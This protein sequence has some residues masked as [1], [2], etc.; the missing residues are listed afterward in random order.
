MGG[1]YKE[2]KSNAQG[3]YNVVYAELFLESLDIRAEDR[4]CKG[5]GEDHEAER[6]RY[7]TSTV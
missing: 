5:C 1:P 4:A 2:I 3:C 6:Q 7:R